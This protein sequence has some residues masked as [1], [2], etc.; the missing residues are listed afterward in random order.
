[1]DAPRRGGE[2]ADNAGEDK[3]EADRWPG[4]GGGG[5]AGQD[6]DAGADDGA[7]AKRD[8]AS[9]RERVTDGSLRWLQSSH[10][11]VFEKYQGS[12]PSLVIRSARAQR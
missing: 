6:K 7:N 3:R 2:R 10:Y 12:N 11:L 5:M 8:K 9:K 1:M 4:M